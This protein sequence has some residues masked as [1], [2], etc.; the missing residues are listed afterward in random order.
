M[1]TFV[2]TITFVVSFLPYFFVTI[3]AAYIDDEATWVK[4]AKR[5]FL[6]NSVI[7]PIIYGYYNS[8][9]RD[10]V[11]TSFKKLIPFRKV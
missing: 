3:L 1:M 10:W 9:F 5:S 11:W 7:N 6:I 2:V 4:F 8:R